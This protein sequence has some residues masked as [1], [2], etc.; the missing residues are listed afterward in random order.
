MTEVDI[1]WAVIF[2]M[3]AAVVGIYYL[4]RWAGLDI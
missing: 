1:F 3:V 4:L 2:G